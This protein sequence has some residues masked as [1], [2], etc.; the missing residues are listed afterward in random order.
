MS[1]YL[2]VSDYEEGVERSLFD[3]LDNNCNGD[4]DEEPPPP[5]APNCPD[6]DFVR[7]EGEVL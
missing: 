1:D 2:R 3:G 7:I 5:C 6:L 4:V